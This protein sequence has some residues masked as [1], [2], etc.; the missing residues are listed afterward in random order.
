MQEMA[1]ARVSTY[2]HDETDAAGPASAVD[3]SGDDQ[4]VNP[5]DD[6]KVAELD[7]QSDWQPDQQPD[8][9]HSSMLGSWLDLVVR[10]ALVAFGVLFL[11]IVVG[12]LVLIGIAVVGG[13]LAVLVARAVLVRLTHPRRSFERTRIRVTGASRRPQPALPEPGRDVDHR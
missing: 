9:G 7:I 1:M 10:L 11:T 5:L 6:M 2:F 8:G 4:V 12:F 3:A 13:Y